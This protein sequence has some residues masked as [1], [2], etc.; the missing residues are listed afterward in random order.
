MQRRCGQEPVLMTISLVPPS[1]INQGE[2]S[3]ADV[4][5]D[6]RPVVDAHRTD[7]DSSVVNPETGSVESVQQ[8]SID[9][10]FPAPA[11]TVEPPIPSPASSASH[12]ASHGREDGMHTF[13]SQADPTVTAIHARIQDARAEYRGGMDADLRDEKMTQGMVTGSVEVADERRVKEGKSTDPG[14]QRYV[15]NL[16]FRCP[17]KICFRP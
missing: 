5:V 9:I 3:C 8:D 6:Q 10:P 1:I 7:E 16:C 15:L 11:V 17:C 2:S 4:A 12:V 13:E 14:V